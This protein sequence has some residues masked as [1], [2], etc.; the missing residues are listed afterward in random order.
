MHATVDRVLQHWRERMARPWIHANDKLLDIGC[1]QGE[2]LSRLGNRIRDSV[3]ID[4]LATPVKTE[5]FELLAKPFAEPLPFADES[6]DGIVMLQ[7]LW[8][9]FA[10]GAIGPRM[11]QNSPAGRSHHHYSSVASR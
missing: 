10:K 11:P 2:F 4:P 3:G 5:H 8:N 6:F 7:R 9:T 1:Y